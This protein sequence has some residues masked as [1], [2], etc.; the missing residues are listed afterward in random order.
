MSYAARACH[1]GV[2]SGVTY[3]QHFPFSLAHPFPIPP[4]ARCLIRILDVN[5]IVAVCP[6]LDGA[7][8]ERKRNVQ[9]MGLLKRE[10]YAKGN[11]ERGTNVELCNWRLVV[12]TSKWLT[13][14]GARGP[15]TRLVSHRLR[16][17]QVFRPHEVQNLPKCVAISR[18]FFRCFGSW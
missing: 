10:C 1:C 17:V 12:A 11:T 3:S 9:R 4:C 14:L 5:I 8:R 6:S 18:Q 13:S 7:G 2:T 15:C 16:E